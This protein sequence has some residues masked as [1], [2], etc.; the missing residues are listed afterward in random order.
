MGRYLFPYGIGFAVNFR[1][2]SGWQWA[3][4]IQVPLPN[5]GTQTFFQETSTTTGRSAPRCST[6][7]WDK[8]VPLRAVQ[9]R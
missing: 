1:V 8:V 7:A 3:R 6:C 5:A 9:G 2:Q 4:L